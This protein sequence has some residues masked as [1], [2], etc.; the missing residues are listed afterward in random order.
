MR[1][2]EFLAFPRIGA[3]ADI[4]WAPDKAHDWE[5]FRTRL[6]AQAPRWTALGINYYRAPEVEWRPVDGK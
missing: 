1:D 6:G 5:A 2:V 4:A 3:I